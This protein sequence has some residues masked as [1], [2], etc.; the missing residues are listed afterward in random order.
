ML[1]LQQPQG[2]E[3]LM[4]WARVDDAFDDHEKV[5]AL[6]DMDQG[7]AAVGL[8]T[9][10]LTYAHRN[11]RKKGKVPGF[12]PTTLPRRFAGADGKDLAS[13]LVH[14][15]LW[16][17]VDDG[18]MIHDFAEYLPDKEVSAARSAAGKK[19]AAAR[20]GNRQMDGNLPSGDGKSHG[21]PMATHAEQG[22]EGPTG[23]PRAPSSPAGEGG[24]WQTDGSL[25][26]GDG[27]L[28][29]TCHESDGKPVANDG[30][31]AGARW[32]RVDVRTTVL[33]PNP[34]PEPVPPS[35]GTAPPRR[36]PAP[37]GAADEHPAAAVTAQTLVAEYI[38]T[39]RHRPPSD[40][41]GQLGKRVKQLLDDG[42]PP[43][44]VRDGMTAWAAK[45]LSPS[46]LPAVVNEVMNAN[47]R[48]AQPG[49]SRNAQILDAAMERALAAEAAMAA[50]TDP[51]RGELAS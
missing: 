44:A 18:W 39:C 47:P 21:K 19:G 37:P 26:S 1:A 36:A 50:R 8:W 35:A 34:S 38:D 2:S 25:P 24:D 29:S 51:V 28:P 46:T 11:T 48:P 27:N 10:C 4:A 42:I 43:D 31:R 33:N 6:L 41:L 49:K 15:R 30:S 23:P 16:D 12:I 9:L 7:V 20:W 14:V 3:A 5:L 32:E 45:G 22:G 40:V 17:Q 13:L